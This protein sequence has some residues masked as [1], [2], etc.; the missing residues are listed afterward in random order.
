MNINLEKIFEKVFKYSVHDRENVVL[1]R[2]V[3]P[4]LAGHSDEIVVYFQGKLIDVHKFN[5]FTYRGHHYI[6][7]RDFPDEID[8]AN[9]EATKKLLDEYYGSCV[10]RHANGVYYRIY[11]REVLSGY[12]PKS[13]E[14]ASDS[15]AEEHGSGPEQLQCD[16]CGE[17][18]GSD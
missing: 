2:V 7:Q 1:Y 16:Q 10:I 15:V 8:W 14:R 4:I 9:D 17:L 12:E 18:S 11:F 13:S 3:I 6:L 5:I